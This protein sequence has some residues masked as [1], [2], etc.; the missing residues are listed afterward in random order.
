[1]TIKELSELAE[2]LY[3]HLSANKLY[4]EVYAGHDYI[5]AEINWG[6]WKH[7]HLWCK[8]MAEKFFQGKGLYVNI[9]T[10][11]TEED[12]SDCYSAIHRFYLRKGKES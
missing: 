1:M 3:K 9:Q 7:E 11:V 4:A 2:E 8:I 10:D 6:D 5:A 12:G